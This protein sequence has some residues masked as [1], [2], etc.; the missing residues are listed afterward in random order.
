MEK[1][2]HNRLLTIDLIKFIASLFVI[3]IHCSFYGSL[4]ISIKAIARFAVPFFFICSGYF[5]IGNPPEKIIKKFLHI[6]KLALF[7]LVL[8]FLFFGAVHFVSG[9]M[10]GVSEFLANIFNPK[11]LI[12]LIVFNV[13][14]SF[15]N[16]WYLLALIYVYFIY[17]LLTKAKIPDKL[18]FTVAFVLLFA[19]LLIWQLNLSLNITENTFYVRNFLFVGFPMV[20]LGYFIKKY[21]HKIPKLNTVKLIFILFI[22]ATL[23]VLSRFLLGNKSLPLGAI[24]ISVSLF[25]YALNSKWNSECAFL[26]NAGD[27]STY[28]YIFHPLFIRL[29]QFIANKLGVLDKSVFWTNLMPI[30]V[31]FSTILFAV[32][33]CK[34]KKKYIK[35]LI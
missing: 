21:Q 25:I 35:F 20:T 19:H 8:Y 32:F 7:S 12:K 29:L 2:Q 26:K 6:V 30:A 33:Y 5:L 4:G 10:A 16:L 11:S 3:F 13:P 28:I 15:T 1:I 9:G 14:F 24:V 22:G 18:I 34:L 27:Y 17:Y 31:C 23:S